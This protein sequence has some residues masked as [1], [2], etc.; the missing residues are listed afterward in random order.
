MPLCA[1]EC[2]A[3]GVSE[4]TRCVMEEDGKVGNTSG[5][6]SPPP[7]CA[8][9]LMTQTPKTNLHFP[10]DAWVQRWRE[11]GMSETEHGCGHG[12]MALVKAAIDNLLDAEMQRRDGSGDYSR[13]FCGI[14]EN[15]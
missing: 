12:V 2:E 5:S 15:V 1:A 13:V 9:C 6:S 8:L 7:K 11:M 3:R 10:T 14:C 4:T